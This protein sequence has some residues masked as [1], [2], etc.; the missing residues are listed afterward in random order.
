MTAPRYPFTSCR[1]KYSGMPPETKEALHQLVNAAGDRLRQDVELWKS[2]LRAAGWSPKFSTA[3]ESPSGV[4]YRGP[5]G[6]WKAMKA[7]AR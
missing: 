3:W 4:L 6:A 2:E 7:G 1:E 5:Y